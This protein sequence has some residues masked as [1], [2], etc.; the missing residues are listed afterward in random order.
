MLDK[1]DFFSIKYRK[2][3]AVKRNILIGLIIFNRLNSLAIDEHILQ[4]KVRRYFFLISV[5]TIS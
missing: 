4:Q 1:V 5:K 3:T 2:K